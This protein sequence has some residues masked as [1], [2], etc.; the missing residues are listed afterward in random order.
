MWTIFSLIEWY[1]VSFMLEKCPLKVLV[2]VTLNGTECVLQEVNN[3]GSS[4]N[5]NLS[6]GA[7]C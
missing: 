1:V 3:N 7:K 6:I 4:A 5:V 2:I